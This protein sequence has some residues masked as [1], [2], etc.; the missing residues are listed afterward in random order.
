VGEA[1]ERREGEG[2]RK[3]EKMGDLDRSGG[4]ATEQGLRRE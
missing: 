2:Q 1:G 3:E 4:N